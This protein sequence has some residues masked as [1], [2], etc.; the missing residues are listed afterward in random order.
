MQAGTS[1]AGPRAVYSCT[2]GRCVKQMA[3]EAPSTQ[4]RCMASRRPEALQTGC[5]GR[6]VSGVLGNLLAYVQEQVASQVRQ[7]MIC[8]GCCGQNA[9]KPLHMAW[10]SMYEHKAGTS[11]YCETAPHLPTGG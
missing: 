3:P 9:T 11:G 6:R 4:Q 7:A 2:A 8:R 10:M 5:W 1:R